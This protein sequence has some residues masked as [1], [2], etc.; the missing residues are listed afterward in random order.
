MDAGM[1]RRKEERRRWVGGWMDAGTKE[2][3]KDKVETLP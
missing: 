3:R 2:T 1:R